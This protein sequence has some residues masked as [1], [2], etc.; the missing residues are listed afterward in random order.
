MIAELRDLLHTPYELGGRTVGVGLDCLG[1]V[2]EVARRRGLP[3]PDGWPSIREAWQR[4]QIDT[5]TGFPA[6][7]VR[8]PAGAALCDGDVMLFFSGDHPWCAIV[9]EQHV[10]TAHPSAGVHARPLFRW[11]LAPAQVWRYQP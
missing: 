2:A 8:Q 11:S 6:G 9:H 4:G 1:T 5:A 7:W 10:V 3:P